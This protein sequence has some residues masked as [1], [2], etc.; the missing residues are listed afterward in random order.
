M[1]PISLALST[2]ILKSMKHTVNDLF[3]ITPTHYINAGESGIEHFNHLLNC[4]I[5][6]MNNTTNE[7]VNSCYALL[8][9]KGH[10]KPRNID[11]TYRTISTSTCPVLSRAL[12]LYIRYFHK[13]KWNAYQAATQYHGEGSC[14]E[15]A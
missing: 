4:I 7:E 10:D 6:D 1:P 13:D 12:D 5:E 11:Q 3:S 9:H 15:L 14:H 8:I 2:D